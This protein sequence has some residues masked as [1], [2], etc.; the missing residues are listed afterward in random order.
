MQND[1][2]GQNAANAI[3]G[4]MIV[5]GSDRQTIGESMQ[6]DGEHPEDQCDRV[7]LLS[8]AMETFLD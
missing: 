7:Y 2:D 8:E 6:P 1:C 4:T 5:A 3:G